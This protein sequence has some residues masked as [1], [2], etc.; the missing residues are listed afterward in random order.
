MIQEA[1][2]LATLMQSRFD[3]QDR[4]DE[5]AAAILAIEQMVMQEI[6]DD[7]VF[8]NESKRKAELIRRTGLGCS[9]Y[10]VDKR[11]YAQWHA[12]QAKAKHNINKL[13][14]DLVIA[15]AQYKM[16]EYR[17]QLEIAHRA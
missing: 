3:E 7:P 6:A 15:K 14:C 16:A 13:E 10:V 8:S 11:S 5:A 4:Y 12:V 1:K 17:I 9:G 2:H